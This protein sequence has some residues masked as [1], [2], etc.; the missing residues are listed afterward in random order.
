MSSTLLRLGLW[1]ILLVIAA[2]VIH[3]T[4]ADQ[5]L[6][7]YIPLT[8]LTKALALGGLLLVAGVVTRM[9]E[10]GARVVQKN[11]C[12]VC[13]TEIPTGAIY[14]RTHLRSVLQK[15]EDRTHMTKLRR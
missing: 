7:E 13:R 3:E 9:F 12:V 4:Y 6:A 8:M 15:E 11:R 5:Q 10:K 2:Y 1:I 14:C